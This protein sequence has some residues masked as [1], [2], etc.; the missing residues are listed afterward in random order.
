[1]PRGVRVRNTTGALVFRVHTWEWAVPGEAR[2]LPMQPERQCQRRTTTIGEVA[3]ATRVQAPE[4]WSGAC[5]SAS[6]EGVRG[7]P[8][9][10]PPCTMYGRV[11]HRVRAG[12]LVFPAWKGNKYYLLLNMRLG[13]PMTGTAQDRFL[14]SARNTNTF[15]GGEARQFV[16]AW[17]TR[18]T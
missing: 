7:N 14:H 4:F 13:T 12:C 11:G 5:G 9:L 1:M 15:V 10:H 3:R 8:P 6:D 2:L 18:N 16:D 17:N